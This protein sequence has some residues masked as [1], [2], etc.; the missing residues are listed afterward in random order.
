MQGLSQ[1]FKI[2][3][4]EVGPMQ[5]L[6]YLI[7]DINT[8]KAAIIDP[9]WDLSEIYSFI[10]NNNLVL[11][12]ILLTHSHH[13]HVNAID[14]ILINNDVQIHINNKEK[15]FWG[16]I[17]DNFY[18][19]SGDDLIILGETQIRSMHT[20]GHTPG[21]VCYLVDKNLVAGDTLFVFGCGRCD[22]HGGNPEEMYKTLKNL[23]LH[24]SSETLILPG[25]NYSTKKISTLKEQIEGN[26]FFHFNDLSKFVNYRM[27]IHDK[28]RETPY[29]SHK[30]KLSH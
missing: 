25:H 3:T 19:N 16:K 26:P 28:T 2:K 5:N 20:P 15:S 8:N 10:K 23:K 27:N 13:D 12:K 4:F 29:R 6:V 22:L 30:K 11:E 17:Y 21:S 7:W 18:I 1:T 9:A 24:L 14:E